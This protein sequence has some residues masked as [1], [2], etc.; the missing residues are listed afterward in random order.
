MTKDN[1]MKLIESNKYINELLFEFYNNEYG[2]GTSECNTPALRKYVAKCLR[3]YRK[4]YLYQWI[5]LSPD[6][7]QRNIAYSEENVEKLKHF[8]NQWFSP[9]RY[10]EYHWIIEYGKADEGHL[11]VHCL[12]RMRHKKQGKNHAREL[13]E[14]WKRCIPGHPLIGKDYLSTNLSGKYYFDKLE[15][16]NDENKGSHMNHMDLNLEGHWVDPSDGWCE[17]KNTPPHT[18]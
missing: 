10:A 17:N 5:T 11:H 9:K 3:D 15:Y 12:V 7:L 13:K 4:E 2:S 6:Y 1:V 16:F 8:C 14:F 18:H